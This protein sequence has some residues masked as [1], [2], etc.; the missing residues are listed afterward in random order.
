MKKSLTK[1]LSFLLTIVLF[2]S[3][4]PGQ[5]VYAAGAVSNLTWDGNTARWDADG[6]ATQYRVVLRTGTLYEGNIHN[7]IV[8]AND[9][10]TGTSIDYSSYILPGNS[11][12]FDVAPIVG[13]EQQGFV[14]GPVKTIAG[15]IGTISPITINKDNRT[16]TWPSV[17]GADGYDVWVLKNDSQIGL[18]RETTGTSFD[19]SN[20]YQNEG[21]G[22]YSVRV[23]AYKAHRGNY[24]AQ[25]ES[26]KVLIDDLPTTVTITFEP[27]GGL[28]TMSSVTVGYAAQYTLP[29][30]SFTPPTDKVF[31]CWEI[32]GGRVSAGVNYKFFAD[33]TIKALWKDGSS[34]P[35]EFTVTFYSAY[36]TAPA[37]QTIAS[38]GCATEPTE[39]TESGYVFGGWYTTAEFDNKFDFSTPITQHYSLFAK[40]TAV[41]EYTVTVN[42]DGNGIAS[43]SPTSGSDGTVVTLTATP[44][45]GYKFK[46]WTRQAG[47]LSGG[48]DVPNATSATTTF[49]ISGYNVVVTAT[50][51]EDSA[52][53]YTVS[54]DANGGGGAMPDVT[55]VP[56]GSYTL[57]SNGFTAPDGKEFDQWEV[58]GTK[59]D[60]GDSITI[61]G[62]T[63][64]KAL[65]KDATTYT[66]TVNNDGNGTASASPT[67]GPDGTV[68]TLTAI[69]NP[70]YKFKEWTRQ[71]GMLSG[72]TDVPNATSATTTFTISGYNVEVTATFEEGTSS[73]PPTITTST[74]PGGKVNTAYDQTLVATGDATITWSID[75]GSLPAGLTLGANGTISGTPTTA[76][77]YT[78]T[79]KATNAAG[80]DTKEYII[81][82]A[83]ADSVTY[84]VIFNA[85]GH[86]TA[87][88][89]QTVTSGGTASEPTAPTADGWTF[90]GWYQDATCSVAFDF[91]T[92]ITANTELYAKWTEVTSTTYTV[93]FNANGHGT[94]PAVQTVTSGGTA[95]EPTA[96][97]ADGWTFGGWY[98]DATCSVAF[99]FATPITANTELY[100]KWIEVTPGT[101][102]YTVVGG[103]NSSFVAG[104]ASD[105]V[106]TVKRS[107][108]DDTCFS[109]FTGVQIDGVALVS[110][111]DYT[112]V[113]GSTVIT[114]K[115]ETLNNLSEGG[116]TIN[117]LFDDGK[118]ETSVTVKAAGTNNNSNTNG[119][120]VIPATGET[121]APTLFVGIAFVAV[122]GMLFAVILVQK[123]RKSVR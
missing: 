39:P 19:F 26:S 120:K 49:T 30:C 31:D 80:E 119:N 77:N 101:V 44:N 1:I 78:F 113:A 84:T 103:G 115:K 14:N 99:D 107:E 29:N 11:Y 27:N 67:S 112:A 74:L 85:N 63:I 102:Y 47:M 62:N 18:V 57:P 38:G 17:S 105:L 36:G 123:K 70:G 92:P 48:T 66:V 83:P 41:G 110:G 118:T 81:T 58:A 37:P 90:G 122:A 12:R 61:S 46:E 53:T 95:S 21:N 32:N 109:H 35:T 108:A 91:A 16:A 33:T 45:P 88:A 20:D 82:I 79:V 51:E 5:L 89:T 7:P 43:A 69:P 3:L 42:T 9:T 93:T 40:W 75:S 71:A 76:G 121:L 10:I 52:T 15:S 13:S 4:I 87:P 72:G 106:I 50:F 22:E 94:A 59:Y 68:V 60:E 97:T 116:H 65:W 23:K 117:V 100:A 73:V 111:T 86:G 34:T 54:F 56:A 28:G 8:L 55:S 2:A 6:T 104:S 98:Q 24:L 25:G 114:I 64:V 96:P